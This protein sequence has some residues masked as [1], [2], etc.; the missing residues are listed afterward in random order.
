[1]SVLSCMRILFVK[2]AIFSA[3][4]D[5]LPVLAQNNNCS[6]E[7]QQP[8]LICFD[9]TFSVTPE[10]IVSGD[11]IHL[12]WL[13]DYSGGLPDSLLGTTGLFYSH[14]FDGGENFTSPIELVPSPSFEKI[15]VS[16]FHYLAT[17]GRFV[18]LAYYREDLN[19]PPPFRDLYTVGFKRSTDGGVHWE[20]DVSL[21]SYLPGAMVA[22]DS[23]I[24]IR[25]QYTD[26]VLKKGFDG[27]LMSQDFGK[28][29]SIRSMKL[30]PLV[31]DLTWAG[32][33]LIYDHGILHCVGT[34]MSDI[35]HTDVFYTRST[36]L[37]LTW[38]PVEVIST[39]DIYKS[40]LPRI[41]GDG[42][43]NLYLTFYD[44]KYGSIDDPY[45]S[46]GTTLLRRSTNDGITWGPE[47][48]LTHTPSSMVPSIAVFDKTVFVQWVEYIDKYHDRILGRTSYDGGETWCDPVEVN[49]S[50][51]DPLCA[52]KDSKI[53]STWFEFVP[54]G[55]FGISF[56]IIKESS[57]SY[58]VTHTNVD[59]TMDKSPE[60]ALE[61]NYPNPF[62]GQTIIKYQVPIGSTYTI[63]LF[64][65][66]G[67]KLQTIAN[68]IESSGWNSVMFDGKSLSS[69]IY[70]Y[71]LQGKT[72]SQ[73]RRLLLT[74]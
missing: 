15:G 31:P 74:K 2:F 56:G 52:I 63:E 18:Y 5:I 53:F 4:I 73:T 37:G 62:N 38:S 21:G 30:F 59:L 54:T 47:Q 33:K 35:I 27:I 45:G 14:S 32:G 17:S 55:V 71:R 49:S 57:T 34:V 29:F 36:D 65:L 19:S 43:G 39:V 26:T 20:S 25:F 70:F 3:C 51:G 67:R 1:M 64:D 16:N 9:S 10:I 23:S 11:T 24:W 40:Q 72:F 13:N 58:T 7:W 22:H 46:H 41:A 12:L 48:I 61:Q 42:N 68:G 44:F 50:G 8:K 60:F 66:L 6:Q 28:T 69:G